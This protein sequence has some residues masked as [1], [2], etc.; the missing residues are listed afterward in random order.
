MKIKQITAI[1]FEG[2]SDIFGL[3]EDNKLY[4]WGNVDGEW[5]INVS[6]SHVTK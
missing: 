1:S 2:G 6:P 4:Y 5:H 3:G